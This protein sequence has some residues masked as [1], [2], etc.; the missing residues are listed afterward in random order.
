MR[1]SKIR[2]RVEGQQYRGI[3]LQ[4][5]VVHEHPNP[6]PPIGRTDEI[7][8]RNEPNV[9]RGEDEILNVD[10]VVGILAKPGACDQGAAPVLQHVRAGL[11]RH[12]GLHGLQLPGQAKGSV[13]VDRGTEARVPGR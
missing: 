6:D 13:T 11:T 4:Q 7:V 10:S 5:E 8:C 2:V 3:R 1:I 9:V 12:Q